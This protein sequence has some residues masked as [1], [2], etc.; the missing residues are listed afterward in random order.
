MLRNKKWLYWSPGG[1]GF[2][3]FETPLL[4]LEGIK[5]VDGIELH[6]RRISYVHMYSFVYIHVYT[7]IY[8]Y[9]YIHT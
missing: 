8:I 6:G 9:I 5:K 7:Y 2:A 1:F 4:A 3:E